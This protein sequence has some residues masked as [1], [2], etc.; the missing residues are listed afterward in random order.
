MNVGFIVIVDC[1]L[2]KYFLLVFFIVVNSSRLVWLEK[3]GIKRRFRFILF[4]GKLMG[5]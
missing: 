5:F 2:G 3:G 1:Y 4:L